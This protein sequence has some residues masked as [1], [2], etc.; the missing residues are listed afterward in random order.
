MKKVSIILIFTL[1]AFIIFVGKSFGNGVQLDGMGPISNGRGGT[2]I[3]HNDNGSLI[4]DNP[5]A[6]AELKGKRIEGCFD[7]I[8]LSINYQDAD[9]NQDAKE[10]IFSLPSF[11]YAQKIG[12]SSFGMGLGVFNPAAFSTEYHLV[13]PDYGQQKYVSDASL[14]KILF[15]GGWKISELWSVGIGLGPAYSQIK[16][17]EPYTFQTGPL[18]KYSALVNI[19]G[20]DWALA[21]NMGVQCRITSNTTLGLV[22]INQDKFTMSG[23]LHLQNPID[24]NGIEL[25]PISNQK[26]HYTVKCDFQWPQ[27]LGVGITHQ[28]KTCQRISMDAL[29]I[30]WSSAFDEWTFKLSGGDNPS[31]DVLEQDTF[32]LH[33]KNSYS[34][35]LGYEYFFTADTI[36]LG[37]VYNRNPVP[38]STLRPLIPGILTHMVSFGYGRNWENLSWNVAYQYSFGPRQFVSTS[39]IIGE[40]YNN[41]SVKVRAHLLSIGVQYQF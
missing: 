22:Y 40:D 1:Y 9:N 29:W 2:N 6:L 24:P 37:Y 41:S 31:L 7:F 32:P 21:W 34:L 28:F 10:T 27:I 14:T 30:D 19:E 18:Q 38:D 36:R 15:G 12:Q 16:F 35:R 3:A 20:D 13:H 8:S 33:W 5:S 26:A 17:E 39:E 11:S 23:D 25:L 4:H